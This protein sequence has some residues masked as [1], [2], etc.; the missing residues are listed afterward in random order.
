MRATLLSLFFINALALPLSTF[1][2][3]RQ[4][5][6][7]GRAVE[8]PASPVGR[9]VGALLKTLNDAD[10]SA[11]L[12]F[13]RANFSERMLEETPP[14]AWLTFFR[15]LR[16]QSGG[17]DVML[18]S[19][20]SN[21]RFLVLDVRSRRGNHWARM[22]FSLARG[23]D[24]ATAQKFSNVGIFGIRDPQLER[25]DAWSQ[26][27]MPEAD[28]LKE[29]KRHA[30]RLAAEDRFS[31]VVLV[32]R[33]ERVVLQEAYGMAE[34]SFGVPNR[35]DTKFNLGSMNK[36]FTSVA[37]AQLVERGKLS[38]QDTLAKVLPEYPNRQA[39][40]KITVHHLL[41]HTSGL[42]DFFDNP[43]FRPH[44]E[45]Y[46]KPADYF[47][48][49]AAE[50][51]RFEPGARFGY[52]NAGF[53]VLG[54]I[55]E[56]VSG[57]SYFDYVREHIY[58]PAGMTDSDSYELTEVVPN[59]AVGYARFQDDPMGIDPRR[60][61]VAFLP[62]RGSPAG[63]GY[64]SAPDLLKF[65][66]ALG[67]H[68]LLSAQMT[69]LV[70]G[71]K[72]SMTGSPRAGAKYGYG[73]ASEMLANAKEIRGHSGGGAN[74]GVNSSLLMFWDGSYTVVV[75]GNYDAP[76]AENLAHKICD[77]LARQ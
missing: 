65:A 17:I 43:Q 1:A 72:V 9:V 25:A 64:A 62:W 35:V 59:L 52:S 27:K 28:T 6:Q 47:P 16:Q 15:K 71:A 3:Q 37:I 67:A 40:E 56:R 39:A 66:R 76:A 73:F 42:G 29:I 57:Q 38:F 74:S 70:T 50:T 68:K 53:V 18:V 33:G 55:V 45:R 7:N 8:L 44:R 51:L 12:D 26:S 75:T 2:Q 11:Q 69:E 48:L 54:A 63:G 31:G 36:M 61:N 19:P 58:R 49:F 4:P 10:A 20:D 34:K 21:E 46:V 32:A 60:S 13:I 24:A 77:F 14:D 30:E 22:F 5:E 23:G 41:T